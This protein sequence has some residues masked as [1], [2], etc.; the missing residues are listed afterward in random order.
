M[1]KLLTLMSAVLLLTAVVWAQVWVYQSDFVKLSQPH[2]VVVDKE[3]KVW[4]CTYVNNDSIQTAEGA[5]KKVKAL[6]VYNQEGQEVMSVKHGVF[7]GEADTLLNAARGMSTDNEGNILYVAYDELFKFNYQTG[8]AMKKVVPKAATSLTEAAATDD[9]YIFVAHVAGGHP[10]WIFDSDFNLYSVAEDTNAGLQRSILVTGDGKH[11]YL[12]KIYSGANGIVEYY[13]ADGVD[14]E[15]ARVDTFGT[16]FND[17][18]GVVHNMWGQCL[19]WGPNGLMWVGTYWDVGVNDFTGWYALDPTQDWAIVD[20][21]G[22]SWGKYVAGGPIGGGKFYS[23][24]GISWTADGKTAY[25]A[26][27]DG[28]VVMKFTNENPKGPGSAP[29]TIFPSGIREGDKLTIAFDFTLK[30]NYPNP[31]NPTTTIPFEIKNENL[32][33]LTIYDM[34]GR[35]VATVVNEKLPAG[36]YNYKFDASGLASGM[37]I[38]RLDVNGQQAAKNMMYI[39]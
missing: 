2:S 9:G 4:I 15:Y 8:E 12:G 37:Y 13:G 7:D 5:W 33:K 27:F 6:K 11:F 17:T 30:Q 23:P 34:L 38:Y 21:I 18:G 1:K 10:V 39:K 14:G 20:T 32:V 29:I 22:S 25:I 26:D 16:V 36:S 19:D 35:E 3:N 31:F 28:G 24:R